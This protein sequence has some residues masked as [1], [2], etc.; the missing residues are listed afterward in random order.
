MY[1]YVDYNSSSGR[2][3]ISTMTAPGSDTDGGYISLSLWLT[4]N[5]LSEL[6]VQM[7]T[8][9]QQQQQHRQEIEQ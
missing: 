9:Q 3:C 6:I 8:V 1:T 5:Q 2:Y 4:A 7:Q